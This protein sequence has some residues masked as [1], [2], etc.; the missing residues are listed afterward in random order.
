MHVLS[1]IK[2]HHGKQL[3]YN[4]LLDL[5]GGPAD[6]PRLQ[7]AGVRDRQAQQPVRRG[8]RAHGAGGL[9]AG[10]SRRPGQR[11]RAAS[12]SGNRTVDRA[13]R[14]EAHEQFIE[15]L[16]RPA[17]TDAALELL[18]QKQ[19]PAA[20]SRTTSGRVPRSASATSAGAGGLLVQDSDADL[21]ERAEWRSSPPARPPRA[22]VG[23]AALRLE[24]L[25]ARQVQ[26]DRD[27][28]GPRDRGHRRRADEPRRLGA[29][30]AG[31]VARVL[32]DG[33]TLASDAFFPF[34]DG[35]ELAMEAGVTAIIQPGGSVRDDE[36]IAAVD[37]ADAAMVFTHRRH[38]RH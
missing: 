23:R 22:E 11:V 2:Q 32:A 9:R 21:V 10:R 24:G 33:A 12:S 14:R 6:R 38:F 17:T 37:A 27:Q 30:R 28:Q 36:V 25:Q 8:G 35:P 29:D 5:D 4:N 13:V 7:R 1:M 15:V 34:S 3:S 16:F 18:T 20:C 19:T 26:R 31:E